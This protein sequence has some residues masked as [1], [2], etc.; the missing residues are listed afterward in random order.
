[1]DHPSKHTHRTEMEAKEYFEQTDSRMSTA[2]L[3]SPRGSKSLDFLRQ[4]YREPKNSSRQMFTAKV[5][6]KCSRQMFT[7]KC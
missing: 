5:R 4:P 2:W 3:L 7:A 1:M 6:G